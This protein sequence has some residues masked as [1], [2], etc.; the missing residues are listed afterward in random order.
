MLREAVASLDLPTPLI[1]VNV[2]ALPAD[3]PPVPGR[4]ATH[5]P[6][7][8]GSA[9][10]PDAESLSTSANRS[11]LMVN[12][13]DQLRLQSM[14]SGFDLDAAW[15]AIDHIDDLIESQDRICF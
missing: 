10:R 12:E 5:Q 8:G 6:G 9:G 7:T 4:K 2:A 3:R 14:R 13:E 1:Y 15:D 11:A